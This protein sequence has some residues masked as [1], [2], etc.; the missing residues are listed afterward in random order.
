MKYHYNVALDNVRPSE[1][2]GMLL[3]TLNERKDLGFLVETTADENVFLVT[4]M[5]ENGSGEFYVDSNEDEKSI[6]KS[7]EFSLK[8]V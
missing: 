6:Q 3:R 1:F 4:V 5:T 8:G 2:T 7:I